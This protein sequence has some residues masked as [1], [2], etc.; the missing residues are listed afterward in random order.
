LNDLQNLKIHLP[1]P[2]PVQEFL[3][4]EEYEAWYWVV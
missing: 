4:D 3:S 1:E 2:D